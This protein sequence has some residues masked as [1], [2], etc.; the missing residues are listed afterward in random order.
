MGRLVLVLTSGCILSVGCALSLVGAS[1]R[2][3]CVGSGLGAGN[4]MEPRLSRTSAASKT[5]LHQ[6]TDAQRKHKHHKAI[7]QPVGPCHDVSVS[8]NQRVP[9][10]HKIEQ[11]NEHHDEHPHHTHR[12]LHTAHPSTVYTQTQQGASAASYQY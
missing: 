12:V 7:R 5:H 6:C 8:A 10:C 4:D 9:T 1:A 11:V 2:A 3:A